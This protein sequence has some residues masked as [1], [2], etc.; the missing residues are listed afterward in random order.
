M[1]WLMYML[2]PVLI[3]IVFNNL[4]KDKNKDKIIVRIVYTFVKS[5]VEEMTIW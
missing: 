3:D 5:C 2:N 4:A 1:S